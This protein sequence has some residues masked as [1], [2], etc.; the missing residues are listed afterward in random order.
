MTLFGGNRSVSVGL[1]LNPRGYLAG[2]AAAGKATKDW[3]RAADQSIGKHRRSWEDI[4]DAAGKAGLV[5]GAGAAAAVVKFAQFDK[6]MSRAAAGTQATAAQMGKLR[7]A[8]IKAGQDTQYSATEAADAITEMGKAG[9]SVQDILG[10]GLAGTLSLAAA[11]ELE[12][13]RAAEIAATTLTQFGLAGADLPHVADLLA[14]GA[15]KAQGSVDDLGLALKYVGPVAKSAGISVEET[16]GIIAELASQ[17]IIGEQAGT[18]FRGMLQSLR[19]PSKAAAATMREYGIELYDANGNFKGMAAAAEQ[20]R[21]K[22]A[23]LPQQQRDAALATMFGNEQVTAATILMNG[24]AAAVEKWTAAV[25]EQ[26]YAAKQAGQLMDNLAGDVEQLKGSLETALISSGSGANSGLRSLVQGATSAVNAFSSLPDGVQRSTVVVGGLTA[27]ALLLTAGMIKGA[28]AVKTMRTNLDELGVS[29]TRAKGILVGVGKVAGAAGALAT[30]SSVLPDIQKGTGRVGGDLSRMSLEFANY[31]RGAALAG[32]STKLFNADL[33][34]SSSWLNDKGLKKS[35][36]DASG[37]NGWFNRDVPGF[38]TQQ[39]NQIKEYGKALAGLAQSGHADTAAAAFKRLSTEA[40]LNAEETKALLRL[41][42]EYDG[43]LSSVAAEQIA[44]GKSAAGAADSMTVLE[45]S[46]AGAGAKAAALQ[47]KLKDVRDAARDLNDVFLEGRSAVRDYEA[48]LDDAAQVAKDRA[49]AG[50]KIA[51][52]QKDVRTAKTPE[53]KKN[54]QERLA[55]AREDAAQYAKT[56]DVGTEAGRRNEE[57]LDNLASAA[58]RRADGVLAET[59]SDEKYRA[60]LEESRKALQRTAQDFGMGKAAAKAFIDEVLRMPPVAAVDVELNGV[61]DANTKLQAL[62]DKV[63][64]INGKKATVT[65]EATAGNV[66]ESRGAAATPR[67]LP[68]PAARAPGLLEPRATGGP[69]A[70]G[71]SYLVGEKRA[72]VFTPRQSGYVFPSVGAHA[73]AAQGPQVVRV[74]VK[75]QHTTERPVHLNGP[76]TVVAPSPARFTDWA[77]TSGRFGVGGQG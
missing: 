69:V 66:R 1:N 23:P 29:G 38:A 27:G 47:T 30:L 43:Y 28:M 68:A 59:G 25:N 65:V 71:K 36:R 35:V 77:G 40:G 33:Q 17:G 49:A 46:M 32:E 19:G 54:A 14:A 26:G 39:T 72:E 22:L 73:A 62:L 7:E 16:V 63:V 75:E 58:Q 11:G 31:A 53:Q 45:D 70:G 34:A 24:G 57:I 41:M 67:P 8:A 55:A 5:I 60:S 13:A 56:L 6:S 18:S 44:T 42:P 3:A 21:T 48:A 15:G 51:E 20:L 61:D 74:A 9:V 4:G 50:R 37:L 64:L 10:G 76:I 52:A 12:V 2:L